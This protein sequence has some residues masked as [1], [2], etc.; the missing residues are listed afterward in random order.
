[1]KAVLIFQLKMFIKKIKAS[2]GLCCPAFL[3]AVVC[4]MGKTNIRKVPYRTQH[5][6]D[7][8]S[9]ASSCVSKPN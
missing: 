9:S 1:M 8:S 6:D 7:S 4:H 3:S 2:L 5:K